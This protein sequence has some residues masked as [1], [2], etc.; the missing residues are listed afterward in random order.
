MKMNANE[1]VFGLKNKISTQQKY[2][3][4]QYVQIQLRK[5]CV[6][7]FLFTDIFTSFGILLDFCLKRCNS[8]VELP[9]VLF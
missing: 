5:Y 9:T 8:V 2:V 3:F 4:L 1:F 6:S 7:N